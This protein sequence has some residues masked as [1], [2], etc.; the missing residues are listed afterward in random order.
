MNIIIPKINF[1][2]YGIFI[3]LSIIS[4]MI[5]N[6]IFLKKQNIEKRIILLSF[7]LIF[8]FTL[9]G[10]LIF[11]MITHHSTKV[12]GLS[13]YGGAIGLIISVLIFSKIY[14]EKQN[15][16][17]TSY[18]LNLPLMY[19]IS[20]LGCFFAGCCYGIP[21]NGIFNI[22]YVN[23]EIYNVFPIQL[24]ETISFMIIFIICITINKKEK[25]YIKEITILLSAI[26]KFSLDFLRNSHINKI[27]SLNQFISLL[28]IIISIAIIIKKVQAKKH[29]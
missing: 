26:T 10:G 4:A 22:T 20:K 25:T 17:Y 5:F 11:T 13:S 15:E 6:Y 24:L 23:R 19:S 27:I 2:I 14:N 3:L 8:T 18:I 28:F 1:P 16:F 21:Y 7:I 12:I 29:L 9:T